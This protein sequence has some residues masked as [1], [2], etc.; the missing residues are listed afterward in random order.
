M[1]AGVRGNG[2]PTKAKTQFLITKTV[3]DLAKRAKDLFM[4]SKMAEKQQL[5]D[6]VFSN[7]KWGGKSCLQH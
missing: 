6:W 3:F 2:K 1:Q 7:L 5:L 4:S